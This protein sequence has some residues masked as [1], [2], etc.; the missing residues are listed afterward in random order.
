MT[1]YHT[2][3][4]DLSPIADTNAVTTSEVLLTAMMVLLMA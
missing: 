2:N 1:H 4:Q 3:F